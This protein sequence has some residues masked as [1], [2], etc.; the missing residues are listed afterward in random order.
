MSHSLQDQPCR[1]PVGGGR[2]IRATSRRSRGYV[3]GASGD[4]WS[5]WVLRT[6]EV[7]FG[8]GGGWYGGDLG[9]G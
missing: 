8:T 5:G 3:N 7:V 2:G 9:C 4:I 6:G 1:S